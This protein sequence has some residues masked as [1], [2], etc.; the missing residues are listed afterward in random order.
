MLTVAFLSL[1][2]P[3]AAAGVAQ[4]WPSLG[5]MDKVM[6]AAALNT[7]LCNTGNLLSSGLSVYLTLVGPSSLLAD[8][9]EFGRAT[10]AKIMSYAELR[11]DWDQEGAI[12]PHP[13]AISDALRMLEVTPVEVGA[14]KPMVLASGDI[15]LYWDFGETYAEIG[16]DGS[17]CY[18]AFASG[19][20]REPVHLDDV[21]LYGADNQCEFPAAIL[22][23]LSW[24][25]LELAA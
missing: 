17:G 8:R 3:M 11:D 9:A 14:P 22:E 12:A 6:G 15:A 5:V 24:E 7:G 19:Q 21:P 18:Y 16:F 25:P 23:I 13:D 10:A 1:T 20:N 2:L 4:A